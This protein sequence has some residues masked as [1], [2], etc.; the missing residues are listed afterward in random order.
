MHVFGMLDL[1]DNVAHYRRLQTTP[2]MLFD[3][4]NIAFEPMIS[5]DLFTQLSVVHA[6][7]QQKYAVRC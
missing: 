1:Y 3:I 4:G 5:H 6:A 7:L 2:F